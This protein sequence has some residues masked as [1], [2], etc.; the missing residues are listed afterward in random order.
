MIKIVLC[1][2]SLLLPVTV[3]ILFYGFNLGIKLIISIMVIMVGVL[4]LLDKLKNR[5]R[6]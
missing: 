3:Y 2:I 6:K 1:I 4:V 5:W